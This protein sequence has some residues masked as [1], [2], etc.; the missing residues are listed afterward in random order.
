VLAEFERSDKVRELRRLFA[1]ASE[2]LPPDVAGLVRADDRSDDFVMFGEPEMVRTPL[3]GSLDDV[4]EQQDYELMFGY[5]GAIMVG[6]CPAEVLLDSL[7]LRS[8]IE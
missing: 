8:G 3:S 7:M 2:E 4:C 6:S 5:S 1:E